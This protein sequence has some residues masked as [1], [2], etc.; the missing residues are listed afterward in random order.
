MNHNYCNTNSSILSVISNN[1]TL[2]LHKLR[3]TGQISR[4]SKTQVGLQV[5][6]QSPGHTKF[7]RPAQLNKIANDFDCAKPTKQV[8]NLTASQAHWNRPV[9]V[10]HL[11]HSQEPALEAIHVHPNV[12]DEL[13]ILPQA[14]TQQAQQLT[15]HWSNYAIRKHWKQHCCQASLIHHSRTPG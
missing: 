6:H 10:P 2:C 13:L 9:A 4:I 5:F 11:K 3:N 8:N 7:Q 14:F 12:C 1:S 15:S